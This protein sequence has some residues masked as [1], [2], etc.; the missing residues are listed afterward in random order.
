MRNKLI[1][2]NHKQYFCKRCHRASGVVYKYDEESYCE[3]CV[4][5]ELKN[6]Q[7]LNEKGEVI[8]G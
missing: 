4:P 3:L 2:S 7:A 6:L 8:D 5:E 1:S